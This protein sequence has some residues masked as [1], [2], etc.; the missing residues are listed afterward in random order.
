M[1][2]ELEP[3]AVSVTEAAELLHIS[4]PMVYEL[5]RRRDFP[6][7]KVGRRTLISVSG[8][9]AWVKKQTEEDLL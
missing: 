9:R 2:N 5:M 7:F 3:M 1:S 4:R 6:S 8:L